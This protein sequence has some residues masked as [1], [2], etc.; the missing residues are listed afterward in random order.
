MINKT[1]FR[2]RRL[3]VAAAALL[4]GFSGSALALDFTLPA[5]GD[6]TIEGVLNTTITAGAG[7][8]MKDPSVDLIGKADLNP[9]VCGRQANGRPL[10]Q[11]CQGLFRDQTFPAAHLT[12]APGQFSM[13]GDDGNLNYSKGDLISG[14]AKVTQDLSLKWGD[15]GFF[16]K[17]L[18]FYDVVN[19]D[20]TETH[21]NQINR[22]NYQD[23][24]VPATI[25]S[26]TLPRNDSRPCTGSAGN[27]RNPTG[28][29]PCGIV[30]GK[31]GY[32]L[33]DRSDGETLREI[34][35]DLQFLDAYFYGKLPLPLTEKELTFKIGRQG[36]NWG[37]STL[38]AFGAINQANPI[39]A[40]NFYRVGGQV[41]EFFTP[42]N[43]AFLSFEPFEG[44]T[45]EGYYQLEWKPLETPAPGSYLSFI[46]LGTNDA[47]NNWINVS[48]GGAADDRDNNPNA[49]YPNIYDGVHNPGAGYGNLQDNALSGLTNTSL[50]AERL[51]DN[52]PGWQGQFG[53]ALKYYA[54]WLNNGTELAAY[55]VNYHSRT[56][57]LSVYS[58][59]DSCARPTGNAAGINVTNSVEFLLACTQIPLVHGVLSPND[60]DGAMANAVPFDTLKVQL[61]YPKDIQMFGVSFNTTAGDL[62]LQGEIAFRPEE[63]LQV[64][65][66]DLAFA[67][68]GPTLGYCHL[69]PGSSPLAPANGCGEVPGV[70]GTVSGV[71][72]GEGGAQT[73][74]GPSDF[75]NADGSRGSFTDTFD[76]LVGHAVG[77]GR[78]FPSYIIPY[79]GALAGTNPGS[80]PNMPYDHNNPGY[81]R[82]WEYFKTVNFNL[83]GTY[84]LGA[85]DNPIGADQVILLFET[86]AYWVPDLPDYDQLQLE[87]PGMYTHASAGADGSGF[88]LRDPAQPAGPNNPYIAVGG[89]RQVCSDN[90]ACSY[91]PDGLRF[92]P[93]QLDRNL[94]PDEL[95]A[96]YDIIALIRYES[97]LP[98]ISLQPQIIWKHDVYG[99]SPGLA[100]NFVEGRKNA[101][102][103]LELRYRSSMSFN[104]GYTWFFGGGSANLNRDRD[105]ARTYVKFQF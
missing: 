86:G 66:V 53:L 48:F 13:N 60:P 65:V 58:T 98:G 63:P 100:T 54:E 94:L 15:Y 39:N 21:P 17:V 27:N 91:G 5:W 37:E 43:M 79:R 81:I 99:T 3:A 31:G 55:F 70:T 76:L 38:L 14:I 56:P 52:E 8:R 9:D 104:V 75:L 12:A 69:A 1:Q 23:V 72:L 71:G 45:F 22:F 73:L 40:N 47:G 89:Q 35:A 32:V 64:A 44:A 97:L 34:G 18:Y 59:V 2:S 62:S 102:I 25:L 4:A 85:T 16:G 92:N 93:H 30:Y 24:G 50:R 11:S 6:E 26:D 74:Y 88:V 87:A 36:V 7:W 51:A 103:L 83:G 80:N 78:S 67:G 77:S 46:D 101:D 61:E 68:F 20:F 33:S 19:N 28:V 10:W 29:L 84:I 96:G 42:I 57:M 41:E 49:E 95:S 90:A 105:F 82:G